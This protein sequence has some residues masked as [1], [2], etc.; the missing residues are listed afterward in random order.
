MFLCFVPLLF[1]ISLHL[2]LLLSLPSPSKGE[3]N[4]C[5]GWLKIYVNSKL[6]EA[7]KAK[8]KTQKCTSFA[9]VNRNKETKEK[10]ESAC[11]PS[12]PVQSFVA[13]LT[14]IY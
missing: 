11:T 5:K 3:I 6:T 10:I 1:L 14:L 8:K 2:R 12:L 4:V 7:A 13:T 9:C